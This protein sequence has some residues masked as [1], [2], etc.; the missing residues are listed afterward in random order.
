MLVYPRVRS[1]AVMLA[2]LVPVGLL[3]APL[4][5]ARLFAGSVFDGVGFAALA[6]GC[7]YGTFLGVAQLVRPVPCAALDENGFACAAGSI[8][9]SDV[10]DVSTYLR[11]GANQGNKRMLRLRFVPGTDVTVSDRK[12]LDSRFFG[13]PQLWSTALVLPAW[14]GKKDTLAAIR[15]FYDGPVED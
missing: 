10:T 3:S 8:A 1:L 14:A 13:R 15:R 4:A 11:Y 7:A 6:L 12:F 2:I 9:W 5:V